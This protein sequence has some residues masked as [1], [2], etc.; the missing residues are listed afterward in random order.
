MFLHNKFS[1]FSNAT[2]RL[3]QSRAGIGP[4]AGVIPALGAATTTE[5]LN[6]V[7][8]AIR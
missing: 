6:A 5:K 4:A 7:G 2:R 1:D 3:L 8:K